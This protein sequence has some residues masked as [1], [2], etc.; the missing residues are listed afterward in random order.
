MGGAQGREGALELGV[1]VEAVGGGGVAEEGQAVGVEGGGGAVGFQ[2]RAE[3]GEVRPSGVAGHESAAEDFAGMVV[4][5]E[6]E[7]GVGV[8]GPPRMG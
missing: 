8:G 7:G 5:G 1:G 2:E 4:E 6:D 3:V